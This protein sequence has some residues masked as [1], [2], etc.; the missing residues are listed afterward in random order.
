MLVALAPHAD[1]HAWDILCTVSVCVCL[2]QILCNRYLRRGLM[3]GD[4]IWQDGR[5]GW[6]AGHLPLL[7]TLD[8]GLAPE[9]KM[10]TILVMHVSLEPDVTNWLVTAIGMWGYM[11]FWITGVLVLCYVSSIHMLS[12]FIPEAERS[13]TGDVG[14]GTDEN[15]LN[16]V[17]EGLWGRWWPPSIHVW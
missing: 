5:A 14:D 11:P 13:S 1:R 4:E 8:K 6:V 9:A 16:A 3:Q 15:V 17:F 12:N 7:W 2:S 10:C